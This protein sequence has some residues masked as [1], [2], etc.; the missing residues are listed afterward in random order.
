VKTA[1]PSICGEK[2]PHITAKVGMEAITHDK[3]SNHQL[4]VANGRLL[5][6]YATGNK[7]LAAVQV[8][9]PAAGK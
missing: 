3:L 7:L 5:G 9:G 1:L 4:D 2:V 8:T 6:C